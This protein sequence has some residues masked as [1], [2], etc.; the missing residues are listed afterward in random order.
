METRRWA[1]TPQE[2]ENFRNNPNFIESGMDDNGNIIFRDVRIEVVLSKREKEV[3]DMKEQSNKVIAET[4]GI[5]EKG[6]ESY[7]NKIKNKGF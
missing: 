3:Y 6:V 4:L 7:R 1:H 5:S 2:V